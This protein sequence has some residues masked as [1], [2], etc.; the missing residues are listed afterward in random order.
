MRREHVGVRPHDLD[1]AQQRIVGG[2]HREAL[3]VTKTVLREHLDKRVLNRCLWTH[4][5]KTYSVKLNK[6]L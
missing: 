6:H 1:L 2:L 3:H 4:G 5:N